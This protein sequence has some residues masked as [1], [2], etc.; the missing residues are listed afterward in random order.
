MKKSELSK[1]IREELNKVMTNDRLN[2]EVD[3]YV[4]YA[5]E[6]N[7]KHE[8]TRVPKQKLQA[9]L[10]K[11]GRAYYD[12]MNVAILAVKASDWDKLSN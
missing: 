6:N 2:E 12:E 4:V 3:E 10:S 8:I 1:I 11:Y 5:E 9:A 7:E